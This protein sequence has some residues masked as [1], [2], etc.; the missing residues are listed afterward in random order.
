MEEECGYRYADIGLPHL[1]PRHAEE[2]NKA[3]E[4][5][6]GDI[7]IGLDLQRQ[8]VIA[9]KNFLQHLRK[10]GV[11]IYFVI[12]DLLPI[13]IPWGFVDGTAG[14]HQRWLEALVNFDGA[15]CISKSVADEMK[16]W[17]RENFPTHEQGFRVGWFHLGAD[18]ENSIP[19]HGMPTDAGNLLNSL[20]EK[21]SFLMVGTIE[22]R[23]G[24]RQVLS[25]FERMWAKN[26][27]CNLAIVGKAGWKVD[28]LLQTLRT[29]PQRGHRLFWL[30][31]ISDQFLQK[32][33]AGTTCLIAASEHEGFGLPLIEAA[34]HNLPIIARDIPVF[35]E[36]TGDHAWFFQG[37]EPEDIERAV[38]RWLQVHARGKHP[39]SE[40][41][42]TISWEESTRQL[43][44][45]I[46]WPTGYQ[47]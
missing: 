26:I 47:H 42:I 3:I 34:R 8:V 23:K 24:Y 46:D 28:D 30:D 15:L 11:K 33:Y 25:A 10:T 5:N 20:A 29:H 35:R 16:N 43:L 2:T 31:G 12:Y 14:M 19:S 41:M 27:E 17:L 21:P 32:I 7:F 22:P 37:K 45:N 4:V 36:V 44:N 1:S 13:Q 9:Q 18:I 40:K 38:S 39:R 6:S